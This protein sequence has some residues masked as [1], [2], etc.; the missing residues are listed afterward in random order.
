MF[1]LDGFVQRDFVLRVFVCSVIFS[2]VSGY[3]TYH[4]PPIPYGYH[5]DGYHART[6]TFKLTAY[7]VCRVT[8]PELPRSMHTSGYRR[9]TTPVGRF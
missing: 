2:L 3:H 6:D 7:H 4:A 8:T 1:V 5:A 9:V